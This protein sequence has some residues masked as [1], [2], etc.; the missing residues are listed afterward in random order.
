[1]AFIDKQDTF[2]SPGEFSETYVGFRLPFS[3]GKIDESLHDNT[4]DSI[5]DNLGNLFQTIPGERVFHPN[6]GVNFKKLLFE[7][8]DFDEVEYQAVVQEQIE[9]QVKRWMPFL[10]VD[11]VIVEKQPD[12]NK[13]NV[14]VDFHVKANNLSDS[15][16]FTTA[17]GY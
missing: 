15:V 8:M 5:K 3:F 17:G 4:I 10:I 9:I 7:P 12:R 6:L 2:N 11:N 14:K 1:M 13:F 16:Q